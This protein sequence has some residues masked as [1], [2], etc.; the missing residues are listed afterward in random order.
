M[1]SASSSSSRTC[2]SASSAVYAGAKRRLTRIVQRSGMTLC[3]SGRPPSIP[4]DLERLTVLEP[5]DVDLVDLVRGELHQH[6]RG[7]VDGVVAHPRARRVRALAVE[8]GLGDEHALA[9]GLDPAVGR[10]EQHREVAGE[11]LGLALR[12]SCRGR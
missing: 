5:V 12:R 6:V 2:A 11:Q 7:T 8:P 3:L 4:H 9:A 10:L 1:S